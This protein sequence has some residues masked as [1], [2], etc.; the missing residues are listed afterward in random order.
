MPAAQVIDLSPTPNDAWRNFGRE[1]A[2]SLTEGYT[3]KKDD[4]I[5]EAL[6]LHN[7]PDPV[8]ALEKLTKGGKGMTS[9]YKRNRAA[10]L[11]E[12]ANAKRQQAHEETQRKY[13]EGMISKAEG[14][15]KLK[16]LDAL[17]GAPLRAAQK[18]L[19]EARKD[20]NQEQYIPAL[21]A[22][23]NQHYNAWNEAVRKH[24]P[25]GLDL[26]PAQGSQQ[27]I[28]AQPDQSLAPPTNQPPQKK[29]KVEV[30]PELIDPLVERINQVYADNP[31][32]RAN[33]IR[34]A[35]KEAYPNEVPAKQE[36]II[37]E[38]IKGKELPPKP[39]E[40]KQLKEKDEKQKKE[41]ERQFA[42]IDRA[43]KDIDNG[44]KPISP[45]RSAYAGMKWDHDPEEVINDIAVFLGTDQM[46]AARILLDNLEF[47]YVPEEDREAITKYNKDWL[48]T[49]MQ[50][51]VET[52]KALRK[53]NRQNYV[54]AQYKP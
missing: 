9:E 53:L 38:K 47:K 18:A 8:K 29:P 30:T 41:R 22:Q 4:E 15:E 31:K 34:K 3:R 32:E 43:I 28:V 45:G 44:K 49:P 42:S 10:E 23:V 12:L 33:Q 7:E 26:G 11:L 6:D 2:E 35:V 50:A 13:Y 16:Y 25:E 1:F 14:E 19:M 48:D 39:E 52:V 37:Q 17:Y 40:I 46:Q 20:P 51:V 21:E 27:A 24:A 5:F 36:R 54:K